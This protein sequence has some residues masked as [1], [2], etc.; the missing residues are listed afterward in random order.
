MPAPESCQLSPLSGECQ[1]PPQ[2]TAM[3][4]SFPL[5]RIE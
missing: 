2:E 3:V 4:T 1:T 5:V